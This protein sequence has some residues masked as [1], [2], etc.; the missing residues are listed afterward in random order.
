MG[1]NLI[2]RNITTEIKESFLD[3]SMS[4][5]VSRALP[6]VRDGL[7][8]V[9][10]R[11]LHGMNDSGNTYD[12]KHLKCARS[13][14]EIMGKYHPHGDGS[15]Y[16]SM[17]RMAQD[18]AYRYPL[19]D[20][21]G[22]F[23][24]IDGDGAAAMRYTEARLSKISFEMLRDIKKDTVDFK[25]NFDGVELEPAVLPSRYPN[26]LVNGSYGIAVGMATNIP[27]HNL[28]EVIDGAIAVI[29]NPEITI[30]E[31]MEYIKGPDFPT[32]ALILGQGGIKKAYKTGKGIITLRSKCNIIE[33][34]NGKKSIII[35][36]I[37]YQVNKSR[38]IEKIADLARNKQIEG[39]VDLRDES[40][41][42][43][44]IRIV[45]ELRRDANANVILNNLYKHTNIQTS[46]GMNMIALVDGKPLL[47]TLKEMLVKYLD[48]Q[49]EVIIRKTKFE[50]NKAENRVHI[51]EGLKKALDHIDEIIK[52]IKKAE[53]D[54]VAKDKLMETFG[55]T[56]I[57]TNAILEM[58]LRRLTGLERTKI[59]NEV[60][61]LYKLINKLREILESDEKI[62]NI[63]KSDM[64]EIK[65]KYSDPRRTEIDTTTIEFIEDESLIPIEE[66]VVSYTNAG[67]IKRMTSDTYRTQNRGGVG[68]KGM[69]TNE[70]D[71]VRNLIIMKTHDFILFFTNKGKTYRIKGYEIPEYK[72]VSKGLPIVNILPLDSDEKITSMVKLKEG[73]NEG[74][75]LFATKKGIVKRTNISE[76]DNIRK[77]GK[78][79]ITL[80]EEDELIAVKRTNGNN[81][82]LIGSSGGRLTRFKEEEIRIMGRNASGV[83]GI[84][85]EDDFCVGAEIGV[86]NQ[87]LLT[88]SQNGYGKRTKI[89]E[90]RL[91]KRGSKG[92]KTLNITEKTGNIVSIKIIDGTEDVI[93]VTDHGIIIR[94][95]TSQISQMGRVTQGVKLINLKEGQQVSTVAKIEVENI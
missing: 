1:E 26:L 17:V 73:S 56:E 34:K 90:Y 50:L 91:T 41:N 80:K 6:D 22:N 61:E 59:E 43:T 49:K 53:S 93:I 15:I 7:K 85:L 42:R 83:I 54:N 72:R 51:L 18:F 52:I 12:K 31:L 71:F 37:P 63:I 27:P 88:I 28:G 66:I 10:R 69:T 87:E 60:N 65:E 94:T 39:I 86:G 13:V 74:C 24:S 58:K 2:N 38:M 77:T 55:F 76:F 64:N 67:Y 68:I 70:E 75:L 29:N 78:I 47:L 5:I 57:Q 36:E 21:H 62:F 33:N 25:P 19:V 84:N 44:G 35:T 8:P 81:E 32:G 89:E 92:V 45:I 48:H 11:I 30:D 20:G 4:V 14:G 79:A 23:G 46:F 95:E 9:H 3:Y 40:S 82:V 16:D